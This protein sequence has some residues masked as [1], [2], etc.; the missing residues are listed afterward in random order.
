[1]KRVRLL[2]EYDGSPFFGWQRQPDVP[3]VQG[4]LEK[5]AYELNHQETTVQ[6]AGRTDAGV[7]ARGQVAHF[8][9]VRDIPEHKV[10]DALNAH[11]R[12]API[13]ILAAE[14]VEDDFHARFH[15]TSRRYRYIIDN[16]R[17]DLALDRGRS[18]RVGSPLDLTAMQAGAKHLIGRHDFTTFR[19]TLCQADS[20]V[21]TLGPIEMSRAGDRIELKF[22]A[23]SFLHKQ[24][25]SMTGSL[26]EV[27]RGKYPPSWIAEILEAK[28]RTACGP[29][30][31]PVGLYLEHVLYENDPA[32]QYAKPDQEKLG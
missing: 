2:I 11:L 8:D 30:A 13:A 22:G 16:R 27:G 5:A 23:R 14:F 15:A 12:P 18:W 7:H 24:V 31:P 3:T 4:D 29:V 20:P 25:R 28:D 17:A 26:V 32:E 19:D 1:M 21:R 10:A 6:G 9:L